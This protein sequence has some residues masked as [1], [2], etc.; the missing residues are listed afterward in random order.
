MQVQF[1]PN[2]T[3]IAANVLLFERAEDGWGAWVDLA[4]E[5]AAPVG[6]GHQALPLAGTKIRV[7][8]PP[9]LV[10]ELGRSSTWEGKITYRGSARG[11]VYALVPP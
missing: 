8:V 9:A 4:V 1:R 7:F 6:K 11:G 10:E 3:R 2:E 5:Q